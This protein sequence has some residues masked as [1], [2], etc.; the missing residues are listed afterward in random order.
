MSKPEFV[1]M[2]IIAAPRERV[3]ECMTS[4]EFTRQYWHG[5]DIRSDFQVGS[6][7]EFMSGDEAGVRGE[8]LEADYPRRLS[9]TWQFLRDPETRDEP[10]SRVCFELEAIKAG[11]RLT[12]VHDRLAEACRTAELVTYGWPHVISGLK[13]LAETGRAVDFSGEEAQACPGQQAATA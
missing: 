3:W 7:V 10:P 11:T 5:T 9:Y 12:V 13:T 8:I 4:P 6:P 1:Y 2:A